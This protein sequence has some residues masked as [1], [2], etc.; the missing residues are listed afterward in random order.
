MISLMFTSRIIPTRQDKVKS[1]C[2]D[3]HA[4][5]VMLLQ[6]SVHHTDCLH[7][8]GEGIADPP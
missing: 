5:P 3:R 2:V 7:Q 4:G 6:M 8:T 1:C